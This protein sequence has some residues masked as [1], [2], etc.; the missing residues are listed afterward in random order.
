G[1]WD[2][3]VSGAMSGSAYLTFDA[4]TV[5]QDLT[6]NPGVVSGYI[7]AVPATVGLSSGIN[8]NPTTFGYATLNGQWQM[9]GNQ[10]V[11]F[12]Y[13]PPSDPVRLDIASF[14]GTVAA[15]GTFPITAV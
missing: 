4:P 7:I 13:T 8:L 5:N 2:F 12:L 6:V 9:D 3:T 15:N 10:V 11:G 14:S 1:T